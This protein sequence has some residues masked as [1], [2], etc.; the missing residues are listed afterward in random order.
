MYIL[1]TVTFGK[2]FPLHF[3]H[4][5]D[6]EPRKGSLK[7]MVSFQNVQQMQLVMFAPDLVQKNSISKQTWVF[8]VSSQHTNQ[9]IK[10][11][12]YLNYNAALIL[13]E[14]YCSIS[15]N[16]SIQKKLLNYHLINHLNIS[17]SHL[18]HPISEQLLQVFQYLFPF[19]EHS[20]SVSHQLFP[21][22]KNLA[23]KLNK[24]YPNSY[25]FISKCL[26]FRIDL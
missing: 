3:F 8:Q 19:S 11:N 1:D 14:N 20:F 13:T 23:M 24:M 26:D 17:K 7:I 21:M 5:L 18:L 16:M 4:C 25:S 12:R 10:N 2:R 15:Q 6:S 22:L 9:A